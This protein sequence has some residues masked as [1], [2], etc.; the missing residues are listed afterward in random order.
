MTSQL[1][2]ASQEKHDPIRQQIMRDRAEET[3]QHFKKTKGILGVVL[4]GSTARGPVGASSDIDMHVIISDKFTG[5]LPEWTFHDDG[6]IENLHTVQ[7]NEILRG[8]NVRSQ[9]NLLAKW[10]YETKLGDELNQFSPLWWVPTTQWQKKLQILVADRQN[11]DVAQEVTRY[12]LESARAN[13]L[14]ANKA[15]LENA[16]LDGHQNLRSAFQVALVASLIQRG[17]TIRGS[18][19]RIEIAQAFLP[20]PAIENLLAIGFELVGIK[21]TTRSQTM[22]ICESRLQFRVLLLNELREL[23]ARYSSD[24]KISHKLEQAI[25]IQEAHEAMAYDYYSPMVDENIILGPINHIRCLSGLMRVP[26]LFV[27]CLEDEKPWPVQEFVKSD[28]FSQNIR[29]AWLDIMML[30]SSKKKCVDLSLVLSKALDKLELR[31]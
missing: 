24:E 30:E 18:K 6:M 28:L 25:Q 11:P 29:N 1:V 14:Q 13:V 12:Y 20:D 16:P 7:E 23:K 2:L 22:K 8:W 19:K 15:C 10:F 3:T 4:S 26:K 21:E 17:W 9:P 5:N 27:S 31:V